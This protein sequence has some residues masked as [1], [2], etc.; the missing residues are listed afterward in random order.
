MDAAV[1]GLIGAAIGALTSLLGNLISSFIQAQQEEKKWRR[2]MELQGYQN[3]QTAIAELTREMSLIVHEIMFLTWTARIEP[4]RVSPERIEA[5]D[6]EIHKLLPRFWS[7]LNYV[8]ALDSDTYFQ[9]LPLAQSITKLEDEVDKASMLH[10]KVDSRK[11]SL[12]MLSN[13]FVSAADV[14]DKIPET[15]GDILS[16]NRIGK[17]IGKKRSIVNVPKELMQKYPKD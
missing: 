13:L 10:S 9:L 1:A 16:V 12:R 17:G 3:L 6:Q 5:Y 7:T 14:Y 11:E 4:E 15:F 8:A 2:S